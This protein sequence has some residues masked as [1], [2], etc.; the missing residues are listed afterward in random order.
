M[1]PTPPTN[2]AAGERK[3]PA[4]RA[5][6]LRAHKIIDQLN[7]R[8]A[9]RRNSTTMLEDKALPGPAADEGTTKKPRASRTTKDGAVMKPTKKR[10]C[11]PKKQEMLTPY[12]GMPADQAA[13]L[14]RFDDKFNTSIRRE[15]ERTEARNRGFYD[16][17]CDPIAPV[18]TGRLMAAKAGGKG[19]KR[20]HGEDSEMVVSSKKAKMT[21]TVTEAPA[22]ATM[23]STIGCS[24]NNVTP[25]VAAETGALKPCTTTMAAD[26][27]TSS[28]DGAATAAGSGKRKRDGDDEPS[29]PQKAIKLT[30][31]DVFGEGGEKSSDEDEEVA[32]KKTD[33]KTEAEMEKAVLESSVR[34]L[35]AM[36]KILNKQDE[37]VANAIR[38]TRKR[39][40]EEEA[41]A[42]DL[43]NWV[44]QNLRKKAKDDDG[45]AITTSPAPEASTIP[46]VKPTVRCPIDPSYQPPRAVVE[47]SVKATVADDSALKRPSKGSA[48]FRLGLAKPVVSAMHQGDTIRPQGYREGMT[49]YE[50]MVMLAKEKEEKATAEK[51]K[52]ELEAGW[53]EENK[54]FAEQVRSAK[55][56]NEEKVRRRQEALRKIREPKTNGGKQ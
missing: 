9:T 4:P 16:N 29:S 37:M 10:A 52:A 18:N 41:E 6:A 28:T 7:E 24:A 40:L 27:S 32:V 26:A 3:K 11:A 23:T 54:A 21:T 17:L 49:A 43:E 38:N 44:R 13:A 46:V 42:D 47:K 15:N 53:T 48:A 51:Q 1:A 56:K 34:I 45:N 50:M 25:A 20:A 31:D 36:Q 8:G 14:K 33:Y 19:K 5:A 30:G 55:Q 12:D 2:N 35:P 22:T 39:E